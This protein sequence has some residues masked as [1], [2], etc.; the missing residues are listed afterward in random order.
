MAMMFAFPLFSLPEK[1][2]LRMVL[3]NTF[4]LQNFEVTE[5][6]FML[7]I[8]VYS[9]VPWSVSV[10]VN[11]W[12]VRCGKPLQSHIPQ[13]RRTITFSNDCTLFEPVFPIVT[14]VSRLLL[15][16]SSCCLETD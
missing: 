8:H 16:A 3:F 2:T 13:L 6:H 11:P 4:S 15:A 9:T 14:A 1:A 10:Q 12:Q 5:L 7:C